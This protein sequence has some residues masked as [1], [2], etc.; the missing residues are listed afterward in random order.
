MSIGIAQLR[1]R[2]HLWCAHASTL[3][4]KKEATKCSNKNGTLYVPLLLH[5]LLKP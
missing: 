3:W 2:S 5:Y 1:E 4:V